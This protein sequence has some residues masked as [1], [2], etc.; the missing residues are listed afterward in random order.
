[1]Q[2]AV[3]ELAR[4]VCEI[5]LANSAELGP[6]C[7]HPVIIAMPELDKLHMGG[8]MRLGLRTTEFQTGSEWSRLR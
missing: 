3:I 8:T 1:M 4:N 2:I 7:E 6:G 5:P